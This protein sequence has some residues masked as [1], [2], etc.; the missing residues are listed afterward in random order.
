MGA[1]LLLFCGAGLAACFWYGRKRGEHAK[2]A[3][4]L[5]EGKIRKRTPE[6]EAEEEML[7]KMSVSERLAHINGKSGAVRSIT[8]MGTYDL[9]IQGWNIKTSDIQI[10]THE[11]GRD[12]LLG[13]GSYGQVCVCAR[14]ACRAFRLLAGGLLPAPVISNIIAPAAP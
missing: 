13:K 6:E 3:E 1:V 12:W 5:A 9:S 4:L 7:S 14:P 2:H 11:D 10:C 8:T